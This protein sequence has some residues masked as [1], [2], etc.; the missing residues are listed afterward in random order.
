MVFLER[1]SVTWPRRRV[2]YLYERAVPD[3]YKGLYN[4]GPR[5]LRKSPIVY[6]TYVPTENPG[7]PIS[8]ARA[9]KNLTGI[10]FVPVPVQI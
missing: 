4:A 10:S 1:E 2:Q 9:N 3:S 6:P 8:T 5:S 7:T